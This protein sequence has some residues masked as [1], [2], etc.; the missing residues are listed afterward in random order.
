MGPCASFNFGFLLCLLS[1][2]SAILALSSRSS[3]TSSL[4]LVPTLRVRGASRLIGIALEHLFATRPHSIVT[5]PHC[6]TTRLTVLAQLLVRLL[7]TL[8]ALASLLPM[9]RL[10]LP[11]NTCCLLSGT[12][13]SILLAPPLSFFMAGLHHPLS[14]TMRAMSRCS[15]A[16]SSLAPRAPHWQLTATSF[17]RVKR[18]L[19]CLVDATPCL[20]VWA[21]FC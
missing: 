12:C 21:L 16:A 14:P 11:L 7:A 8:V 18:L 20:P 19:K 13:I 1:L 5:L 9:W 17:S 10:V 4:V 2:F 6:V 3:A 15:G